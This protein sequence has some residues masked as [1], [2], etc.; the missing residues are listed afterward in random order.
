MSARRDYHV[1]VERG[2]WVAVGEVAMA[3][4][5]WLVGLTVIVG[6][7]MASAGVEEIEDLDPVSNLVTILTTFAV[8]I[9]GCML[10]RR[11]TKRAPGTLSSVA[12]RIRWRWLLRCTRIMLALVGAALVALII[13]GLIVGDSGEAAQDATQSAGTAP[14]S[15]LL[16]VIVLLVPLQA[17]GEEYLFRGTLLQALGTFARSPW[18]GIVFTALAFSAIHLTTATASIDLFIGACIAAWLTIRTGGL[19]AA[20]V[21]HAIFNVLVFIIDAATTGET[22]GSGDPNADVTWLGALIQVGMLA[23]YAALVTRSYRRT[24]ESAAPAG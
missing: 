15:H 13:V 3:L 18:V 6:I 10:A 1:L 24:M 22:L 8:F 16:L 21:E 9:P 2:R 19:E 11:L 5:F 14:L 20:I 12:G 23:I 4:A 17:A 7:S